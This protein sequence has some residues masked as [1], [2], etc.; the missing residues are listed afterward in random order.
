[1]NVQLSLAYFN[2]KDFEKACELLSSKGFNFDVPVDATQFSTFKFY[3][4]QKIN[5][6]NYAKAKETR[7][8]LINNG[9]EDLY[10]LIAMTGKNPIAPFQWVNI[11]GGDYSKNSETANLI[12]ANPDVLYQFVDFQV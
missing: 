5:S 9:S 1:M 8:L 7:E 2:D 12:V 10:V 4:E 6:S 3:S 11:S